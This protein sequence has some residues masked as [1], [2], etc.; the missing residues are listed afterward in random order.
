VEE[1]RG[2][3]GPKE[4]T[5]EARQKKKT[6]SRKEGLKRKLRAKKPGGQRIKG[7]LGKFL[8]HRPW[9]KERAE[10]ARKHAKP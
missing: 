1:R 6:E 9:G 7:K 10:K 3:Q 2:V 5:A 8:R 4:K